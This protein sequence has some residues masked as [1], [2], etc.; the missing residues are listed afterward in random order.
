MVHI[1]AF[2]DNCGAAFNSGIVVDNCRNIHLSGNRSG[3]CPRCGSMGSVIDGVFNV[4]GDVI[5]ILS[6]P[7]RTIDSLQKLSHILKAAT[8]RNLSAEEIA[9]NIEKDTPE[10]S[11]ISKYIPKN[12]TELVAWLTLILLA[13]QTIN[14]LGKG[15]SPDVNIILNH[16]VEQ[17][18]DPKNYYPFNLQSPRRNTPCPCGSGKRYK[19]CC[20][21]TT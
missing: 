5:E 20:G 19:H 14:Q 7:Q 15:E 8:A 1:P 12:A 21:K 18:M 3:P 16:S 10:F 11:S 4:A 9:K 17:S 6:A 2:C 13:I